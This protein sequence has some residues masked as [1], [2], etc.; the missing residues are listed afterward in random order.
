MKRILILNAAPRK[1]GNTVAL[2]K[3]FTKGAIES[4][5][6]VKEIYLQDKT[7]HGCLSCNACR[8][9]K[10][11]FCIQHDDMDEIYPAFCEADVIVFATPVYFSGI[12]GILK[13]VNDRLFAL[14]AKN[15]GSAQNKESVLLITS[16]MGMI[17]QPL[18]WYRQ[19]MQY[20][21]WKNLGVVSG[22]GSPYGLFTV[23]DREAVRQAE[24]LGRAVI[25]G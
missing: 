11:R 25:N 10:S 21:G 17:E 7:I 22:G 12:N 18:M 9:G 2:V 6:E 19:F 13:V 16:N 24:E 20:S 3:A 8:K 14:W 4:G 5:N 15:D 1:E 23:D